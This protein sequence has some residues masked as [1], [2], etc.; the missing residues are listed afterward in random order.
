MRLSILI[1][2]IAFFTVADVKAAAGKKVTRTVVIENAEMALTLSSDGKAVSLVHKPTKQECLE[3][4]TDTPVFALTEY[5]PYD[6]ELFLTY[7]AKPRTFAADTLWREGDRL[8]VGF[9]EIAYTATITLNIT[10]DYIGFQLTDLDYEIEKFGVK[11]KTE[12]DE[13]TLL[14]LPVKKRTHFG[15]W[16]NVVWDDKVAV[17]VLATDQFARIDAFDKGKYQLLYAGMDNR[18]KLM[19][20]GAALITTSNEKLL[21]RIDRLERDYHLPPGVESRRSEAYKYSYYELRGVRT[22]NIDEHIA[23]AKQGGFKMMVLYYFDF[24]ESMGHFPWLPAYPNGM[25]DL[26]TITQKIK[27]A[28]MIPGFHIHYNK[29]A[30]NDAYVSPVPDHRLNLRRMFT[31]AAAID[32]DAITIPVEENPEGCTLENGRRMLKIGN[33]LVAYE[34]YTTERPYCFTGCKRGELKSTVSHF[35]VGFKLGLLDV[36]TWPLFVRFDQNTSIQDE[37]GERIGN[38]C[39]EAGFEFIYFDGAEDVHPPYWY[40][41]PR[42]QLAVYNHIHPAPLLSEGAT[43]SHF[44][45]HIITRGNAFDLFRPEYIREATRKYPM[46]A[47]KYT[48]QDFTSIN[49]GWNDYLAPDST[50]VG[51]QPD[52]YEFICSRAAAWDCPIALMG[53]LNELRKHPRTADNLEVIRNWEEVRINSL[54]TSEQKQQ[55]MNPEQE[56]FLLRNEANKLEL[57]SYEKLE[58]SDTYLR[59]FLFRR[60]GKT[61]VVYWHARGEGQLQLPVKAGRLQL[62]KK[63]GE[64]LGIQQEGETAVLPAG[65]R[66]YLVFELSPKQVKKL[67]KQGILR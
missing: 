31:L 63:V 4:R 16:L 56:H 33:E 18:V 41:V 14:Q 19:N 61:C 29:A 64:E 15:E 5:R 37:V 53:K 49:F 11:R 44:S 25:A 45:W 36:D 30:K 1:L 2:V 28:G 59:A 32:A 57:I 12:I 48:A 23:Y 43:K 6:N 35:E 10:D 3:K 60:N 40:N 24:A 51:M 55:L 46:Y 8:K 67:W 58:G 38:L 62:F 27:D 26:Q 17:N 39:R 20:V 9:Q 47:A 66:R 13:F 22:H 50:S 52:M 42:A 34:G 21:D 65:D 7:P 54:L